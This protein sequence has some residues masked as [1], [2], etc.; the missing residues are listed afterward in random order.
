MR[1]SKQFSPRST[2]S[3]QTFQRSLLKDE[4]EQTVHSFQNLYKPVKDHP[5]LGRVERVR[6]VSAVVGHS[7]NHSGLKQ[8]LYQL[9]ALEI[10]GSSVKFSFDILLQ[11]QPLHWYLNDVLGKHSVSIRASIG[12]IPITIESREHLDD[13][14]WKR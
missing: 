2:I 9:P 6:L 5:L 1:R 8:V 7:H 4:E 13:S 11:K 3:L 10:I 14:L 12:V